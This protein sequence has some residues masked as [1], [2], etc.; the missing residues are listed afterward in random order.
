MNSMVG[1]KFGFRRGGW[2]ATTLWNHHSLNIALKHGV[3]ILRRPVTRETLNM[4]WSAL[5]RKYNCILFV[6][7]TCMWWDHPTQ[8]ARIMGV[9]E[10]RAAHDLN[11]AANLLSKG[12][13]F[14]QRYLADQ[15]NHLHH[16]PEAVRQI[17]EKEEQQTR[18]RNAKL[19]AYE[20]LGAERGLVFKGP[21]PKD[22]SR[23]T[24]WLRGSELVRRSYKDVSRSRRTP[25]KKT[26]ADYK[27]VGG[28][29]ANWVA[30][31]ELPRS[32]NHPTSWSCP[33]CN[34]K[35]RTTYANISEGRGCP[36]CHRSARKT[37]EEC[38][39]LA[40]AFGCECLETKVVNKNE[41]MRWR[42]LAAPG[43]AQD[44]NR[45]TFIMRLR[46]LQRRQFCPVCGRQKA[47][48]AE[49]S[50]LVCLAAE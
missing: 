35:W 20:T 50:P 44:P 1:G 5:P 18:R 16:A 14:L 3:A 13:E 21:L 33:A 24:D 31:Q 9:A 34:Y 46:N 40:A 6:A 42:C 32:V 10:G 15:P 8:V 39:E 26:I 41:P 23:P 38:Q 43:D 27:R 19:L 45:G 11:Y 28:D 48:P 37:I 30:G 25:Y 49:T 12:V 7:G 47:L 2:Q 4:A 17:Y 36:R 29:R 22:R